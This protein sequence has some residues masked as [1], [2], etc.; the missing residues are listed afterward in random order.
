ME[1]R[2]PGKL[3]QAIAV[4][5]ALVLAWSVMPEQQRYW[6]RLRFLGTLH[7]LSARL[8]WRTGHRGMADEL[9][10]RDFG[11]YGAAYRLSQARDLLGRALEEM[12]P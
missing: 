7:R 10:E 4:A 2:Q 11:R 5:S 9:A 3:E 8:A 12:R 6:I 1:P